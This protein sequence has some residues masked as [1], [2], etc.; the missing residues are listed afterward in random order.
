VRGRGGILQVFLQ[1][2][3]L[4][5]LL[6]PAGT[7]LTAERLPVRTY[8]SAD[9]LVMDGAILQIM[10]DSRGFLWFITA[11]GISRFDGQ[12]FKN[13]DSSEG[14]PSFS[15]ILET[16]AGEYW[17]GTER[18]LLRYDPSAPAAKRFEHF[19]IGQTRRSND[20]TMLLEDGGG[21][22]WVGTYD[23]LYRA[24]RTKTGLEAWLVL[25]PE[26]PAHTEPEGVFPVLFGLLDS[27]GI[28]WVTGHYSGVYR[29]RPDGAIE[30]YTSREGVPHLTAGPFLEDHLGRIWL[31]TCEGLVELEP[32]P[33]PGRPLVR[34][35]IET[36]AGR[37]TTLMLGLAE[38]ADGHLWMASALGLL[39]FDGERLQRYTRRNGLVQDVLW[40]ILPDREGNLWAG[41]GSAG[42]MR[43]SRTGL[44]TFDDT[45]GIGEDA[46]AS[47]M[48]LRTGET[49]AIT[50]PHNGTEL[51][52]NRY[53]GGIPAFR[54]IRPRFPA[55]IEGFGWGNGQILLRDHLGETWIA[56]YNGL[57]RFPYTA[58]IDGLD[59]RRP[60]RIYT[61]RD[62]LRSNNIMS[63][64]EDSRGDIWIGLMFPPG[65]GMARWKRDENRFEDL[66]TTPG[67]KP[68]KT[69]LAFAESRSGTVWIGGTPGG[70]SRFRNGSFRLFTASDGL[71][72]GSVQLDIDTAGTVWGAAQGGGVF[73][74]D[75][76]DSERPR[77]VTFT[78]AH[79][80]STDNTSC[81]T[82]DSA[83]RIYVG[84]FKGLDRLD[85]SGG[86]ILHFTTADGLAS[87]LVSNC[88]RDSSGQLWFGTDQGVSRLAAAPARSRV[89]TVR[90]ASVLV[91]GRALEI[92]D[93]GETEMRGPSLSA[94][95]NSLQIAFA[96]VNL[97]GATRYRYML[98]GADQEWKR[99]S[100]QTVD[101]P[102]LPAGDYRFVVQA[103]SAG[104]ARFSPPATLTFTIS[105]PYWRRWWFLSLLAVV[106]GASIYAV[107]RF[108]LN[109]VLEVERVRMRIATDLHD[110]I[111]SAL[112]QIGLLSEVARRQGGSH[113]LGSPDAVGEALARIGA[114]S[115][116][117]AS[118]MAD[119]VWTIN[120]ERDS[121]GDLSA[122][123]RRFA[124]ELFG[125]RDIGCVVSTPQTDED[126]KL[127]IETRRQLLL[128]AK[129]AM[130]N[131]I[132]HA[133]CTEVAI[134]LKREKRFV[135]FEIRD[136]GGGFD[137]RASVDGQGLA[138]MKARAERLGGELIVES[139]GGSGTRLALHVPI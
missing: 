60:T 40:S 51:Q 127:G 6:L 34:R 77:F 114:V 91:R 39:E 22:L 13:H 12:T 21:G 117:T 31:A 1:A 68:G 97:S 120:P 102:A 80:L 76:A 128:V 71:P 64:F 41:T 130:H 58:S 10:Q 53:T 83:G 2:F 107:W 9:G 38:T 49:I 131:V 79:G 54:K 74:I 118:S 32:Q 56:T 85:P 5:L 96:A 46:V 57:A 95:Q 36:Q 101:Y 132:R 125:G 138:S 133:R 29:V 47:V 23:G 122:R 3:L 67:A 124:G 55:E 104:G 73:R 115:R 93:L 33:E 99:A 110:D 61:M 108:R 113:A 116:E 90:I 86:E 43:I 129:E 28:L 75:D 25:R 14:L 4:A 45:D 134:E 44:T 27:R 84:T 137:P 26:S 126:L 17:L 136:N 78:V 88:A 52:I 63:L 109:Q 11:G 69:A 62:G 82:G 123:I 42:V 139:A 70:L 111:G 103:V 65:F 8:T 59:G 18:G 30:H 15:R 112:S 98:E 24:R 37:K 121:L 87:N 50:R 19:P 35:S 135:V 72:E 66:T 119:I 106:L 92:S 100:Q 89:P 20:I 48:P 16:R 105:P 81:V 7:P 94:S